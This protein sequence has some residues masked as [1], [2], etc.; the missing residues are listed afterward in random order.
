MQMIGN[1]VLLVEKPYFLSVGNPFS[2]GFPTGSSNP[3][4][5]IAI[6]S[7]GWNNRD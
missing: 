1:I 7:P 5:K 6:F 4:L 2:P 3:G